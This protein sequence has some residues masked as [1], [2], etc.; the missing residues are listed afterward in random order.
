MKLILIWIFLS[1]LLQASV[2]EKNGDGFRLVKNKF[3]ASELLADYSRLRNLNLSVYSD[4]Q[5]ETFEVNGKSKLTTEQ[6]EAY[7]SK[8]MYLSDN[9]MI[10]EPA[11][12]FITVVVARDARYTVLPVI[13][14]E[15]DI[16]ENDNYIQYQF[17]LSHADPSDLARNMRPFLSRYGRVMDHVH[18]RTVHFLDTGNNV[19]RMVTISKILDVPEFKESKKEIDEINEKHRKILRKEKSVVD[20]LIEN[21][22][23]FLIVFLLLGLI[24]GFGIRGYAMKRIEGGW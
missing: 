17:K 3:K 19:R 11:S 4:F 7:V 2:L 14:E 16:P 15:K 8:V 21:N 10:V 6:V 24:I 23:V 12:P 20:I 9:A 13:S 22:G 1:G 18:A 5:D